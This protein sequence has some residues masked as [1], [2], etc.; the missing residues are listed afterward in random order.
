MQESGTKNEKRAYTRPRIMGFYI[1]NPPKSVGDPVAFINSSIMRTQ[2]I[3]SQHRVKEI[4]F[5]VFETTTAV[6]MRIEEQQYM[7]GWTKIIK[8]IFAE[9]IRISGDEAALELN[10]EVSEVVK[11]IFRNTERDS[12]NKALVHAFQPKTVQVSLPCT[13][14]T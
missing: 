4:N 7:S 6:R 1:K 10:Y 2:H 13:L 12:R 9:S 5:I 8:D 14:N 11:Q 3:Q